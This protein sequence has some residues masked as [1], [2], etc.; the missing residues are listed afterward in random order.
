MFLSTIVRYFHQ[1]SKPHA[2]LGTLATAINVKLSTNHLIGF[3]P[4]HLVV[5]HNRVHALD[6]EGVDGPVEHNPL[7]KNSKK[8]R[9]FTVPSLFR[10]TLCCE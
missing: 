6:P 7:K 4:S 2:P 1:C 10:A 5:I 3:R 8:K 9:K